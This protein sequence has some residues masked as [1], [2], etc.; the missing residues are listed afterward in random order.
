MTGF[1]LRRRQLA[2]LLGGL[3][4]AAPFISPQA[5]AAEPIVATDTQG[6]GCRGNL[7]VAGPPHGELDSWGT[8]ILPELDRALPGKELAK[9][10]SGGADGVTGANQFDARAVPDGETALLAPGAAILAWLA[11]DPRAQFDPSR[12]IFVM[13]GV[14]PSIL[15]GRITA[16]ELATSRTVRLATS[17]LAGPNLAALLTLE[18]LGGRAGLVYCMDQD[19]ALDAFRSGKADVALLH[20]EQVPYRLERLRAEGC[21][22]ILSLGEDPGFPGVPDLATTFRELHGKPPSGWLFTAWRAAARATQLPFALVLPALTPAAMVALWRRAGGQVASSP[23]VQAAASSLAIRPVASVAANSL[24][25]DL[26]LD[27]GTLL[28]LR[29]WL[30]A[31]IGWRG[32]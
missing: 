13:A 26:A 28:E 14:A 30:A 4:V 7:L 11:G 5:W 3:C 1:S 12:W 22:P 10:T 16:A 21:Q 25:E 8:A 31:R 9:R 23:L 15:A 17:N 32:S 29:S 24:P 2:R 27:A 18:L 6:P 19:S 20:G